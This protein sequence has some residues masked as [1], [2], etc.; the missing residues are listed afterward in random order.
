MFKI[1]DNKQ[2]S[3]AY[4]LAISLKNKGL[5][6]KEIAQN[7]DIDPSVVSIRLQKFKRGD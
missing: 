2:R 6:Q 4:N 1:K 5:T 3:E 7:L